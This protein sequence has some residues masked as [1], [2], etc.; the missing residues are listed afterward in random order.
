MMAECSDVAEQQ[1][2]N[3]LALLK[4]HCLVPYCGQTQKLGTQLQLVA[5]KRQLLKLPTSNGFVQLLSCL[6]TSAALTGQNFLQPSYII[7]TFLLP[8]YCNIHPNYKYPR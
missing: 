1:E 5:T 6:P 7:N 3:N 8:N 2:Q 4:Q